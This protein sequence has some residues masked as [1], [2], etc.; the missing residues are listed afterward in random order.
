MKQRGILAVFILIVSVSGLLLVGSL[1]RDHNWGGDFA[2]YIM[3]AKSIIAAEPRA[4]VESNHVTIEQSS[5]LLGPSVYPWGFPMLLVPFYAF[6]GLNLLALKSVGV[7][8]YLLFLVVFW[9]AFRRA[10]S[11]SWFLCLTCLFAFNPTLLAFSKNILSDL[12]F[13]LVSTVCVSLIQKIVV[14]NRRII[15]RFLDLVL[16]GI[17]I[18]SA[19]LIRT[20][21][22]LLLITLGLS[23]VISCLQKQ[24]YNEQPH[25]TGE[26]NDLRKHSFFF[27]GTSI[28]FLTVQ[29]VPYVV[30]FCFV[31]I[32]KLFFPGGGMSYIS[33]LENISVG[34]IK[35]NLSYYLELPYKFFSG[36]PHGYLLYGASIPLAVAGAVRRCR[37]DYPAIIYIALTLLLYIIWPATQGI[38]FLFPIL[39]FYMSFVCSGLEGFCRG[40]T[41]VERGFRKMLSHASVVFVILFFFLNALR[42]TDWKNNKIT[43]HGPFAQ[44]SQEMF[45]FIVNHTEPESTIVFLKP[46]VMK[47]MTGRQSIMIDKAEL[48]SR[49]DYLCLYLRRGAESQVSNDEVEHLLVQGTARAVY[50]NNDFKVYSMNKE[51]LL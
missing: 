44:T 32:W 22:V 12:P 27:G 30:F 16:I 18:V 14:Q 36:V 11:T 15:S 25:I 37:S 23:Q 19:F 35:N 4:F 24:A 6:F 7:I 10:H 31:L 49:G 42:A 1:T 34:M 20:N 28:K 50:T 3:Q 17:A 5:R 48:L 38:R 2:S 43:E 8:S 45:S 29:L 46:R 21:G 39:P 26:A 47:L 9:F 13:L 33:H 51:P 40:K 41:A